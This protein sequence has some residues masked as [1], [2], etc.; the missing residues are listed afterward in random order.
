MTK[1]RIFFY[2]CLSF[3]GGIF[4]S[5]ILGFFTPHLIL[6]AGL[7]L[8]LLPISALWKYK[9]IALAGF[10]ILFLVLGVW[11][12]QTAELKIIHP[13]E[14]ETTFIGTVIQ[15]PDIRENSTKL[16]LTEA[17]PRSI[18][19]KILV[20]TNRYP[21]Y[22]YG[23]KLKIAGKLQ[24]PQKF[25]DFNYR[26]YL[27]KDGIYS[28]IYHPKVEL[29]EKNQGNF[30]YAKILQFK[31]KLRESIEQNLSP[32]QGSILGAMILGDKKKMSEE[33]KGKL[34]VAGVRHITAISGMHIMI[35]AGILMYLGTA[36]NLRRGQAFYFA[37]I[38]LALFILMVGLPASAVRAGIMGG[39]FL[40]AQKVGRLKSVSRAIVMAAAAMLALNPLLLKFDVGF[41]L[42]FLAVMGIIYLM[43][44]FQ[45]W[46]KFIP[47]SRVFPL[48]GLL[49]MTLAA[50]TFTLPILI[51]NFGYM[52]SVSPI[53]NV[54]IVPLLP[55]IMVLGFISGL[56]G[57]I[58]QPLGWVLSWPAWFLLTYLVKVVDF[59]SQFS[60]TRLTLEISWLWLVLVYLILGLL[61]WRLNKKRKLRFFNY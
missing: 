12:H 36:L 50:Q 52:S 2:F 40:L 7:V 13:Q 58:W 31:N 18:Q 57:I 4:I 28:V 35:L 8:G 3:V 49:A 47:N 11:R 20:T 25:P 27:A 48:R 41:Q 45:N 37:I 39:L 59:F 42:S 15:E 53:T 9:K 60:W 14:K 43:P 55:Y 46:L 44:S 23:D 38:L 1:S 51:Y 22:H 29:M 54:L 33:L 24:S 21:E 32:P 16:T 19:G 10:C 26:N 30:I 61:A 5:S 56:A 34:N 6:G 17:K